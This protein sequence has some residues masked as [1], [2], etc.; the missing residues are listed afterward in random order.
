MLDDE[1][2]PPASEEDYPAEKRR[3]TEPFEKRTAPPKVPKNAHGHKLRGYDWWTQHLHSPRF[4]CAPMVEQS[5]LA[6]RLLCL[7]YGVDLCYTPMINSRMLLQCLDLGLYEDVVRGCPGAA[8]Q[9]AAP[10]ALQKYDAALS[11]ILGNHRNY[12]KV[13]DELKYPQDCVLEWEEG[14]GC[15]SADEQQ[16]D[17]APGST[18][19]QFPQPEKLKRLFTLSGAPLPAH[20]K[21]L[22]REFSTVYNEPV[23]AQF[24]GDSPHTVAA[25]AQLLAPHVDGVD[26]NCG[27]PQGIAKKGHYGSYLLNEP[28]L[29]CAIIAKLDRTLEDTPVTCKI[30]KVNNSNTYQETVNLVHGLVASGVSA[31]TIHGRTKEEKG[32]LT[33]GCDWEIGK[34]LKERFGA[35]DAVDQSGVVSQGSAGGKIPIIMNGGFQSAADVSNCFA[36]TKA[37]AVMSAEGLLEDPQL[38][39]QLAAPNSRNPYLGPKLWR[40]KPQDVVLQEYLEYAVATDTPFRFAKAHAFHFLYAGM[41]TFVDLRGR[42]G[43]ALTVRDI[44]AVVCGGS[45]CGGAEGDVVPGLAGYEAR[46]RVLLGKERGGGAGGDRGR[47]EGRKGRKKRGRGGQGSNAVGGE[48]EELRSER[49]GAVLG[50]TSEGPTTTSEQDPVND[51][52]RSRRLAWTEPTPFPE[53][54]WYMRYRDPI[55]GKKAPKGTAEGNAAGVVGE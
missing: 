45:G 22:D 2:N 38:F 16:H 6:F 8:A 18:T 53:L 44:C 26:L 52:L 49:G 1:T 40:R 14:A 41:Q 35:M 15:A 48:E 7:D 4:I 51:C 13:L 11:D 37:D 43:R 50:R 31:V 21:I 47:M 29:I 9:K 34:I 17:V 19:G 10:E 3:R 33:A 20:F 28:D 25:A 55:G 5:A 24:C 32:Q 46:E 30:R 42:L 12:Q 36:Y 54:G 23:I 39:A 27:C